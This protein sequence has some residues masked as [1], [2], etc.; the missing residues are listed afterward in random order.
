VAQDRK[1]TPIY[2]L[3]PKLKE[4]IIASAERDR[5]TMSQQMQVLLTEALNARDTK[6]AE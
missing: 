5:R 6:S 3:D 1:L 4:R 2:N